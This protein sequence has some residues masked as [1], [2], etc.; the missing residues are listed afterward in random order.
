MSNKSISL[1]SNTVTTTK[2]Q[3]NTAVTDG[4][5]VF[6]DSADLITGAKTF[7]NGNLLLQNVAGTKTGQFTNT[8]TVN[9]TYTLK[10]ADGTL[11][12]TTDITGTNSGTNTGDETV[13]RINALYGTA[14]AITVG[15][16]ELGNATDTTLARVSA[17]VVSI[18][19]SNISTVGSA[20]TITGVKT[21]STA[22][23]F[24]ALPT[25]TAVSNTSTASTLAARDANGNLSMN[26]WVNGF[27]STATAA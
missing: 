1:G 25:G 27:A 16:I 9:R 8:N 13:A 10:D 17:G 11:A 18:E 15:S 6:L 22:P 24:N 20:D 12:F 14:N 3:L 21:Y 23:V 19:G 26:N 5:V 2:A 7:T 4:D